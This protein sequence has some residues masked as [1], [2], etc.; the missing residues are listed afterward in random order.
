MRRAGVE[1]EISVRVPRLLDE[2]PDAT[3]PLWEKPGGV[4]YVRLAG[5]LVCVPLTYSLLDKFEADGSDAHFVAAAARLDAGAT[6]VGAVAW[7]QPHSAAARASVQPL[8]LLEAVNGV[9]TPTLATCAATVQA[10]KQARRLGKRKRY[11]QL[12]FSN[13]FSCALPEDRDAMQVVRYQ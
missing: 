1:G 4:H 2:H 12:R 11:V 8:M 10:V 13:H 3:W 5:G 7:V 6:G 9:E